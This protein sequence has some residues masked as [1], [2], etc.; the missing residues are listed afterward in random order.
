MRLVL[1]PWIMFHLV[2]VDCCTS[3][4]AVAWHLAFV[5]V[6]CYWVLLFLDILDTQVSLYLQTQFGQSCNAMRNEI[7]E[8]ENM[9]HFELEKE[10]TI[11]IWA[12]CEQVSIFGS[13]AIQSFP[14]SCT[15]THIT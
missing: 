14:F 4:P 7:I 6:P 5:K 8:Y 9:K 2:T 13:F 3:S 15:T 12:L 1:D 10:H 11:T